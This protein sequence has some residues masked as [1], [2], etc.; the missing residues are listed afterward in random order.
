MICH[1]KFRE[2]LEI[3][4]N[5][6]LDILFQ[7]KS[8]FGLNIID[9]STKFTQCQVLLGN[10]LKNSQCCDIRSVYNDTSKY[11]NTQYDRYLSAKDVLKEIREDKIGNIVNNF[12]SQSL[13][14]KAMWEEAFA[15]NVKHWQ[16]S[17]N[18]LPKNVYNFTTRYLNNTLPTLKNMSLWKKTTNS[19][20][21]P[22]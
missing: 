3:P 21:T 8:K 4:A 14:I 18:S 10:K 22:I 12:T 17:I 13:V 9:V 20:V 11:T 2:W 5:G 16:S 7:A 15:E 1:N 6:T 19:F